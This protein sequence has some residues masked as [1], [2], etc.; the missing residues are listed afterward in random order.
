MEPNREG[1]QNWTKYIQECTI[2]LGLPFKFEGE[3]LIIQY[4]MLKQLDSYLGK[5]GKLSCYCI[6]YTKKKKMLYESKN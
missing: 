5:K 2:G 6:L 1:I 4:M 3:T